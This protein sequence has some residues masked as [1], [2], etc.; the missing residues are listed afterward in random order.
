MN[1]LQDWELSLKDK[2]KKMKPQAPQKGKLV[3][4]TTQNDFPC[5][6]FIK[7]GNKEI[8]IKICFLFGSKSMI[9]FHSVS[10][11]NVEST[12]HGCYQF[13]FFFSPIFLVK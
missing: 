1:D 12:C 13:L 4:T 7:T 9:S 6:F 8:A 3:R 10:G 5:V 11:M 2:D